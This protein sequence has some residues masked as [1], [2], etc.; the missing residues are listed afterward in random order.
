M[1]MA[2]SW[3]AADEEFKR[4]A[5]NVSLTERNPMRTLANATVAVVGV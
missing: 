4:S 2:R 5:V 1:V 3:K